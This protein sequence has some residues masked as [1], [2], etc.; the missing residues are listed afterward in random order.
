[1]RRIFRP[2][3]QNII[4]GGQGILYSEKLHNLYSSPNIIRPNKSR[5]MRWEL[6]VARMMKI[7]NTK[8]SS[9]NVEGKHDLGDLKIDGK[10]IIKLF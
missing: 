2:K 9:D 4:G 7:R 10:L 3:R 5:K 6:Q 1:L 8:F